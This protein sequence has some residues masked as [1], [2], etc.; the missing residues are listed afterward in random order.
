MNIVRRSEPGVT[1]LAL[2][3]RFDAHEV[4]GY[5]AAM[6]QVTGPGAT[7]R[8]DLSA[9]RFLDSTALSELLRSRAALEQDGGQL[10]LHP[11]SDPVRVILELTGLDG[12]FTLAAPAPQQRG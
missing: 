5:R 10:L 12:V 1:V 2:E 7:V 6:A 3:D 8:L 9:I 11:V 4:S